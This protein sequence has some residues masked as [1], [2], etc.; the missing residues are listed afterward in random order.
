VVNDEGELLAC[1]LT[2]GNVDDRGPLPQ[3][4]QGLFGK[5]I[6]DKGYLVL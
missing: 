3:M 1:R 4:A 2:P 6:G 5:L